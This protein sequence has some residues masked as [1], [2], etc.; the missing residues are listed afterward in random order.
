MWT[1]RFRDS[2][3]KRFKF[4]IR[5]TPWGSIEPHHDLPTPTVEET[6]KPGLS[7]QAMYLGVDALPAVAKS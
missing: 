1:V 3:M 6:K 7:G 4:P 2:Q 5:T